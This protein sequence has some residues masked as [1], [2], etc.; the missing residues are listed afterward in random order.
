MCKGAKS[1]NVINYFNAISMQNIQ[2]PVTAL[3]KI[4]FYEMNQKEFLWRLV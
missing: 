1:I 3:M 4:T 2:L